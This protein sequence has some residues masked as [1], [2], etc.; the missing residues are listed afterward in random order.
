MSDKKISRRGFIKVVG[1][2]TLLAVCPATAETTIPAIPYSLSEYTMYVAGFET[3]GYKSMTDI[4]QD[5]INDYRL[6]YRKESATLA[7]GIN[8]NRNQYNGT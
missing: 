6:E 5:G 1:A 3:A 2:S 4:I 7:C 8:T